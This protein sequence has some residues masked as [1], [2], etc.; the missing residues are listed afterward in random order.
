VRGRGSEERE[1]SGPGSSS[2]EA[3][4]RIDGSARQPAKQR[5]GATVGSVFNASPVSAAAHAWTETR[6]TKSKEFGV[7]SS[8]TLQAVAVKAGFPRAWAETHLRRAPACSPVA[9]S[10]CRVL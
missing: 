8:S 9:R 5:P 4:G 1:E 10:V 6:K 3:A 7:R 2:V